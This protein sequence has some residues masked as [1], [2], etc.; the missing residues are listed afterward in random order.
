L[1]LWGIVIPLLV[2]CRAP[3]FSAG[4]VN[5]ISAD[6]PNSLRIVMDDMKLPHEGR[7][8]GVPS[9]CDWVS[10]PRVRNGNHPGAFT[11]MV[12]WGQLY[13]DAAGNPATNT[14]V[15]IRDLRAYGLSRR[16]HRW[17]LLQ[18]AWLVHGAA[19]SEDFADNINQPAAI[20]AEADGS[21]SVTAGNG[22]NFHFYAPA[23][24]SIDPSD[25]GGIFI[26]VQARLVVN[27]PGLPDD[28]ARAR[29]L[30]NVGGDYW[31]SLTAQWD[32][33]K[34]NGDIGIGRFKYVRTGWQ[35]FNMTT[36]SE[37]EIRR[38]PPP[39]LLA[40]DANAT[41]LPLPTTGLP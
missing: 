39:L 31:F 32:Y 18:R 6:I 38:N 28:R 14:R 23:R 20:R 8:R 34:T 26:T 33:W 9:S 19:Y 37:S 13:E 2:S 30:L 15:Q 41:N 17:R 3:L 35:S 36:L 16:D 12:A 4:V 21:L 24:T 25:I 22:Y 10:R 5:T 1:L 7:P 29:Y 27:D 40:G 11:A